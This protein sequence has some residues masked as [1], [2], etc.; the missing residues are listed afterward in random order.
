MN[1]SPD[2]I[3]SIGYGRLKKADP[4]S[5]RSHAS[6]R[7]EKRLRGLEQEQAGHA[8]A[9]ELSHSR[10]LPQS[11]VLLNTPLD[12]V[13]VLDADGRVLDLNEVAALRL[14]KTENGSCRSHNLGFFSAPCCPGSEN[15]I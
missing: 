7:N 11:N 4:S 12:A 6:Q 15:S 8:A 2:K 13:Y 1:Q 14:R 5:G 10:P 3:T 9:A